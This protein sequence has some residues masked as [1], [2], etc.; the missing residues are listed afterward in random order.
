MEST[1]RIN[2]LT[3]DSYKCRRVVQLVL[4][5]ETH[6]FAR[7]FD[8]AYAMEHDLQV[9]LH[10]NISLTILTDSKSLFKRTVKCTVKTERRLMIDMKAKREAYDRNK[11]ANISWIRTRS[12]T[13]DG[14]TKLGQCPYLDDLLNTGK[15]DLD[16]E[17]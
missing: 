11:I 8:A 15:I 9:A 6:A 3:Y 12:N 14:H 5:G 7:C 17:Q 10:H 16:V 1:V 4:A 13:A 2:W